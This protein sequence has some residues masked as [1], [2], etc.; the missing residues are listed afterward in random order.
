MTKQEQVDSE[1]QVEVPLMDRVRARIESGKAGQNLGVQMSLQRLNNVLFGIHQSRYYLIGA[2]SGVGKTTFTNFVFVLEAIREVINNPRPMMIHYYSFEIA[3]EELIAKWVVYAVKVMFETDLHMDYILGR[4]RDMPMTEEHSN[5]VNEGIDF[6]AGLLKYMRIQDAV[7]NPTAI[8]NE[9]IAYA[10]T[11]GRV[12]RKT[13][14]EVK[15]IAGKPKTVTSSFIT[16]Y[17]PNNDDE[18]TLIVIDHVA[19]ATPEQGKTT[20]DTID[21]LSKYMVFLRNR[22]RFSPVL[23]QQFNTELQSVER[24]KFRAA[25]LAPQR[26]DFG[27]SKYTYRDADIVFG[28]LN[29]SFF[30]IEEFYGYS[31]LPSETDDTQYYYLGEF[32]VMAFVMKNRYGQTNLQ[33]PL[34]MNG[35]TGVFYDLPSPDNSLELELWGEHTLNLR[36]ICQSFCPPSQ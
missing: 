32:F 30:D 36:E 3:E 14:S 25:A 20:K 18:L 16:G 23:I 17:T 31:I 21:L 4:I 29:P 33:I 34:F 5:M 28:L 9:M 11:I 10:D 7:K 27:D 13:I 12:H 2:D 26:M 22:F 6:V 15:K 24:R 8:F 1:S 19:L 35:M